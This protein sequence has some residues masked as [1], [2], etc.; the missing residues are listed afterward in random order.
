ML[1]DLRRLRDCIDR[2]LAEVEP[3][4][5][6]LAAWRVAMGRSVD[7]AE[8]PVAVDGAAPDA[9]QA[10]AG[11]HPNGGARPA[12]KRPKLTEAQRRERNRMAAR[13]RRA[14]RRAER[15]SGQPAEPPTEA[16]GEAPAVAAA[17]PE[18]DRWSRSM[19]FGGGVADVSDPRALDVLA[20]IA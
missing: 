7:P 20:D 1:G 15:Q 3:L 14:R 17:E 5:P 12:P 4:L 19:N 18:P 13:S 6:V 8:A 16:N 11:G 2:A 9:P 10:D